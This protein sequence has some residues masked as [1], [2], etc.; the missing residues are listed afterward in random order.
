MSKEAKMAYY[1]HI[2]FW[3]AFCASYFLCQAYPTKLTGFDNFIGS[4]ILSVFGFIIWP[5]LVY[6]LVKPRRDFR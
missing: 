2:Y 3:V 6:G 1:F 5:F 4:V